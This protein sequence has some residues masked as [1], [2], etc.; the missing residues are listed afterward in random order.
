VVRKEIVLT[1]FD[2][3]LE[4]YDHL[5]RIERAVEEFPKVRDSLGEANADA[6]ADPSKFCAQF[7]RITT[8]E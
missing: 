2:E 6:D 8:N 4:I 3:C 5:I 1:D 7:R